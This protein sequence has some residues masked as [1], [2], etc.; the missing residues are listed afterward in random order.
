MDTIDRSDEGD[1][2]VS[3][4]CRGTDVATGLVLGHFTILVPPNETLVRR[5]GVGQ[6]HGC[7]PSVVEAV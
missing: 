7:R 2:I 4:F 6:F 3:R 5:P 1:G